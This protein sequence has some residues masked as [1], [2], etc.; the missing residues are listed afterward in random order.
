MIS[1]NQITNIC[2]RSIN[3]KHKDI[4]LFFLHFI[5]VHFT[6]SNIPK[7][8]VFCAEQRLLQKDIT[9]DHGLETEDV[10]KENSVVCVI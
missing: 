6:S 8:Q 7:R 5:F 10:I 9:L 4:P 2:I 1:A 3:I